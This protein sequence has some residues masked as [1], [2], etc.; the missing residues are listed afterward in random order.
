M[1]ITKFGHCCLLVE[2]GE[3]KILVDPGNYTTEQNALK[4]LSAVLITHEHVDHFHL[5]SVKQ[6][7]ANNPAVKIFTTKIVTELLQKEG[8]IDQVVS[9][10]EEF[11]I[12]DLSIA[13]Y[14]EL[15]EIIYPT[16]PRVTNIGFLF[17]KKFFYPGD[18]LTNPAVPVEV[19]AFPITGP[20]LKLSEA[21]DYVV[22]VKPTICFPVHEGTA[23]IN[24]IC[25]LSAKLL[26]PSGVK[27]TILG[28]GK[29]LEL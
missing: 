26:I 8:I 10:K 13:V 27:L 14:G 24:L 19:L 9:V 22:A 4:G 20:W 1:K 5:A 2:E 25:D 17:N 12:A 6:V 16:L 29:F 18:A 15:H 21:I 7:L 23:S 28:S 3:T 11:F